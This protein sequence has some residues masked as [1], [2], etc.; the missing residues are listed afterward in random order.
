M[1]SHHDCCIWLNSYFSIFTVQIYVAIHFTLTLSC[2]SRKTKGRC[3]TNRTHSFEW[4]WS[5]ILE[6]AKLFSWTMYLAS[7][8]VSTVR[9]YVKD[10]SLKFCL[11]FLHWNIADAGLRGS[12]NPEEKWF[13]F[14]GEQ[15]EAVESYITSQRYRSLSF[16]SKLLGF[17][18]F[19]S[20]CIPHYA[21]TC[22]VHFIFIFCFLPTMTRKC[23]IRFFRPFKYILLYVKWTTNCARSKL[24]IPVIIMEFQM[25]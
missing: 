5:F 12:H 20:V 1:L 25:K 3:C 8:F 6:T 4:E 22:T 16:S 21:K 7:R 10:Q 9:F 18:G 11:L 2:V 24:K 15:K 19:F 17:Y 23:P 13:T 14:D